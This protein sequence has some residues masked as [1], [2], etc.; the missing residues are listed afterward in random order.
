MDL[1]HAA[2]QIVQHIVHDAE[3]VDIHHSLL[4]DADS[5]SDGLM[6]DGGIPVLGQE[7]NATAE[8]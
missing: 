4:T 2:V 7:Q 5:T 1:Y 6:D 3:D 8:L